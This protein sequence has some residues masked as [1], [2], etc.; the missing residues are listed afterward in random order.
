MKTQINAVIV[1]ALDL[2]DF[3]DQFPDN[4]LPCDVHCPD[5][6]MPEIVFHAK[7]VEQVMASYGPDGW[8]RPLNALRH[9]DRV[10]VLHGVRLVIR[11]AEPVPEPTLEGPIRFV[12]QPAD[13][14]FS[15]PSETHGH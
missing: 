6:G 10:K 13:S 3:R 11:N 14:P 9:Y 8:A 4:D 2:K 5:H 1:N 15:V 12:P 7:H